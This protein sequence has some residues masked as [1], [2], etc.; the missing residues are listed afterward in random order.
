M[1]F[2]YRRRSLSTM[3][4]ITKTKKRVNKAVGLTALRTPARASGSFL[5]TH[6]LKEITVD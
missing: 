1:R 4:G 2:R 6:R 5:Y 3:R